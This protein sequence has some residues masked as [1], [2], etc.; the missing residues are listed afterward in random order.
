MKSK[1]VR[2]L[3]GGALAC[4]VLLVGY[5]ACAQTADPGS[6]AALVASPDVAGWAVGL[7]SKYPWLAT[8]LLIIGALR[9]VF[10]PIFSLIDGYVKANCSA[11]E[12]TKLQTFEAGPIYKWLNFGLDFVGSVKLPVIGIK[13]APEK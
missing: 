10:K 6:A 3:F 12:Y 11:D 4:A 13:P 9:L 8:V 7:A 5:G 2:V 1:I